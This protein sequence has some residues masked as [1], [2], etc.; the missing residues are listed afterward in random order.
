MREGKQHNNTHCHVHQ[1][2]K[3]EKQE[4][5]VTEGSCWFLFQEPKRGE[6]CPEALGCVK[7][8]TG[9]AAWHPG[10]WV[11]SPCFYTQC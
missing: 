4:T 1:T 6:T 9:T 11:V 5:E 2:D 3:E 8:K 7:A 10:H